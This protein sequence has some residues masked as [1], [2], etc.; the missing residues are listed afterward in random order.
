MVP[1]AAIII[2]LMIIHPNQIPA[3]TPIPRPADRSMAPAHMP[4][5]THVNIVRAKV[6][7]NRSND[8]TPVMTY[9]MGAVIDMLPYDNHIE[10]HELKSTVINP[11]HVMNVPVN[12]I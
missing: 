8:I 2:R 7:M 9:V 10:P 11:I 3:A 5:M 6:D 1:V 4:M 12:N